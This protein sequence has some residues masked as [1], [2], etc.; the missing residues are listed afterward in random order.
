[1]KQKKFANDNIIT[2]FKN[3]VI[4]EKQP[5]LLYRNLT[6]KG[7]IYSLKQNGLVV[8][9]TTAIC[10]KN[11]EFVI[12]KAGKKQAIKTKIRNVHAFIKGYV[13]GSGMGTTAKVNCLPVVV[14]Y[15]PFSELG[16][17]HELTIKKKEMRGALFV[18]ANH[19]GVKAAYTH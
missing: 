8:A 15:D 12:N 13:T 9:H 11:V 14:K 18:I 7:R 5:V 16:F 1:M 17:Y 4:D 10:L 3:R 6:R 19:E 2:P